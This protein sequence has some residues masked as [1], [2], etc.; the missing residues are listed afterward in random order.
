MCNSAGAYDVDSGQVVYLRGGY[1]NS[2]ITVRECN[3]VL[4]ATTG[5]NILSFEE[6]IIN[7]EC[8]VALDIVYGSYTVIFL[9]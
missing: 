7:L 5:D 1:A 8:G 3:F 6:P 2:P 9:Y 4:R